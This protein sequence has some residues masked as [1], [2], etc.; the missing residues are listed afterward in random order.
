M[1]EERDSIDRG[2]VMYRKG[3]GARSEAY[4]NPRVAAC[5]DWIVV[6]RETFSD[7]ALGI[8]KRTASE[9]DRARRFVPG[10]VVLIYHRV[11]RVSQSRVD[12]PEWLFTEQIARLSE[13][14]GVVTLDSALGLLNRPAPAGPSP[15]VVTFDD[16]TADFVDVALPVLVRYGV[17]A[18][19]YVATE[20]IE[21]GKPFPQDAAPASWS[22]LADASSTGLV[23]IGSHTHTHSLLDRIT[24]EAAAVDLDRSIDLLG[25]RLGVEARHFAYP[26]AIVARPEI[27]REVTSRFQT[28]ALAGTRA[29]PYGRTNPYRLA[30]SPVQ[31]EDGLRFFSK[32]VAGGMRLEDAVRRA[33]NLGRLARKTA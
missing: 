9:A 18:T 30:R 20:F 12:L 1:I 15:V 22:G 31:V 5:Q 24:V 29:N 19:L 27:E 7:I 32:K 26:K 14:P 17:P 16:G 10:I 23:T 13:H 25:A 21:S 6:K 3:G 33:S 28:A 8:L 2:S 11:G 4:A